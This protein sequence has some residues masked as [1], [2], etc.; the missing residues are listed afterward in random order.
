MKR[1]QASET[2]CSIVKL[3][4][5][6]YN[7]KGYATRAELAGRSAEDLPEE[8]DRHQA[9]HDAPDH[10]VLLSP[11]VDHADDRVETGDLGCK[12][13]CE[14]ESRQMSRRN[15]QATPFILCWIRERLLLCAAN[16]ARVAYACLRSRV[17]VLTEILRKLSRLTRGFRRPCGAS[18]RSALVQPGESRS[19]MSLM[20]S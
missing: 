12:R 5:V 13:D 3:S 7:K 2:R 9:Q 1:P 19:P 10:R 20:Q 11:V 16:S 4:V 15:V 17:L 14:P 6:L 8:N 18:C